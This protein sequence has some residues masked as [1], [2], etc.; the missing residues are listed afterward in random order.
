MPRRE[1]DPAPDLDPLKGGLKHNPFAALGGRAPTRDA[2][3]PP[4]PPPSVPRKAAK[5]SQSSA[6]AKPASNST[7]DD[8]RK[9]SGPDRVTVRQ[10]RAGR[11]GKT[12]TI[13]EG[14]GLAGHDLESLARDISRGLGLGARLEDGLLV[15]QGDQRERLA[16]WLESRGFSGVARGN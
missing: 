4:A 11:G 15:I 5:S 3:P 9:P 2:N 8:A 13:A 1:S 10:E 12:V 16:V 7:R 14:P 6:S